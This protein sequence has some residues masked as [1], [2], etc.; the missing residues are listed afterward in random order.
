MP[1]GQAQ[2]FFSLSHAQQITLRRASQ[3]ILGHYR[4]PRQARNLL[5][6][7]LARPSFGM[8]SDPHQ[9]VYTLSVEADVGVF[10]GWGYDIA[11]WVEAGVTLQSVLVDV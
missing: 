11:I 2:T 6:H 9:E 5:M 8:T 3:G 1:Q 10:S 7:S 4:P